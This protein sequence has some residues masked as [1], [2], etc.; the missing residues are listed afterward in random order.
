MDDPDMDW[1][2]LGVQGASKTG[3]SPVASAFAA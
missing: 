1:S 2:P 3:E